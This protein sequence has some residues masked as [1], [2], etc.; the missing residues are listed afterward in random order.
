MALR[1]S[2]AVNGSTGPNQ[3]GIAKMISFGIHYERILVDLKLFIYLFIYLHPSPHNISYYYF[4]WSCIIFNFIKNGI[5]LQ[6][7]SYLVDL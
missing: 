1:I 2:S 3:I 5:V 4:I 7:S 6:S